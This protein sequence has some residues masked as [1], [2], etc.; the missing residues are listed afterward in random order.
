MSETQ[1]ELY[2]ET[3]ELFLQG[4]SFIEIRLLGNGGTA[5]SGFF[6]DAESAATA[7]AAIDGKRNAYAIANPIRRDFG[8]GTLG[9]FVRA[10]PGACVGDADIAHRTWF[11]IDIDCKAKGKISATEE[12]I[13]AA[14]AVRDK[15]IEFLRSL[16]WPEPLVG[17]SGNG[18][19]LFYRSSVPNDDEMKASFE[20]ALTA[21]A[22]MFNDAS[23]AID[24]SAATAARLVPLF[25]TMKMKGDST[26][27][28]PHRRSEIVDSGAPDC[29]SQQQIADLAAMKPKPSE[30]APPT[31]AGK[32]FL[33]LEEM[34]DDAGV[35]HTAPTTAGDITWF[36][37]FGPD[38]NCPFGDSSGNGG[39]CGVGQDKSGKLYGHCFAAEHPWSEWKELLGFGP[40]FSGDA[41]DDGR[42]TI[43]L[44]DEMNIITDQAWA[45]LVEQNDP[46]KLFAFGT[47][48]VEVI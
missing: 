41:E 2:R 48:L 5:M 32:G 16:G 25:G 20:R 23:V 27:E 38:G 11:L 37:I 13:G 47:T 43:L 28:R 46:P 24:L 17:F 33:K 42:P 40:F 30:T 14:A 36:G 3:A 29:V 1:I 10:A 35:Q 18:W 34:L 26:D 4:S 9:K 19:W 8:R 45:A 31:G 15:I 6:A 21:L 12:E 44:N 7:V 22:V 39:K